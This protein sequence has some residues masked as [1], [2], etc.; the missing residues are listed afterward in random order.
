M[1]NT[2]GDN[3]IGITSLAAGGYLGYKGIT[4]GVRRGLGIRIE[5]HT[6]SAKNAKAI[7]KGGCILDPIFGGSSASKIFNTYSDASKNYVHITGYHKD[8]LTQFDPNMREVIKNNKQIRRIIDTPLLHPI[9]V[10]F[11]KIQRLMYRT[12]S[13]SNI[14]SVEE[15]FINLN[16]NEPTKKDLF[17][18]IFAILTG[19]GTK[20]FY[21][22]GTDN[23]FNT[24]FIP[25]CSDFALKTDK[26]LKVC[27]TKLGAMF[28]AL[29]REGLSGILQNKYRT[30][31]G[32]L[33][34][35]TLG[36]LSYKCI[37]HGLNKLNS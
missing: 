21:I 28:S 37:K 12:T 34:A 14:K 8:I 23:Y 15:L 22:G 5:E 4:S 30:G 18:K 24:N 17:R 26:P 36:Y 7:I 19:K 9:R 2:I 35:L 16:K 1:G 13:I 29:K 6:T 20:T 3:T 11:R 27:R 31:A 10:I 25:D 32:I 33:I